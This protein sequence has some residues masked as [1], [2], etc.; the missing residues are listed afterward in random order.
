EA[1]RRR[2]PEALYRAAALALKALDEPELAALRALVGGL[3]A[4]GTI[5]TIASLCQ[6]AEEQLEVA[7]YNLAQLGLVYH[8]GERYTIATNSLRAALGRLVA[9]E[10]E[11][12][13]AVPAF[14][15]LA[16]ARF[17]DTAWLEHEW[18]NL[19]QAAR[20]AL[21]QGQ[22][23]EAASL[24]RAIQPHVTE[25]GLWQSWGRV[26]DMAGRAAQQ[27]GDPALRAWVLHEQGT[28]AGLLGDL[29]RAAESLARAHQLRVELGDHVGAELTQH[30]IEYFNLLVPPQSGEPEPADSPAPVGPATGPAWLMPLALA[31]V[32]L[33]AIGVGVIAMPRIN[34]LPTIRIASPQAGQRFRPGETIALRAS[35]ADAQ[36]QPLPAEA[37][38]WAVTLR[39]PSGDQDL[40][41]ST[42][43]GELSVTVPA[44]VDLATAS[45]GYLEIVVA[46]TDDRGRRGQ[47]T[48]RMD[49]V[50]APLALATEPPGFALAINGEQVATPYSAELWSGVSLELSAPDSITH[51]GQ[52]LR[53]EGW[54]D[55]TSTPRR[56]LRTGDDGQNLIAVFGMRIVNC[57][58]SEL[59]T[60]ENAGEVALAVSLDKPSSEPVVVDYRVEALGAAAGGDFRLNP[61]TLTFQPGQVTLPISVTIAED[62]VDEPAERLAVQLAP[63]AG[64]MPGSRGRCELTIVD[65]DDPPTVA[66]AGAAYGVKEG[67]GSLAFEIQLDTASAYTATARIQA[68]AETA[69]AGKDFAPLDVTLAF[70]PGEQRATATI[71]IIDDRSFEGAER[72]ALSVEPLE[73]L[74][75]GEP[76]R[77]YLT[78]EDDDAKPVL[79]LVGAS[80]TGEGA[81]RARLTI[82]SS[83]PLPAPLTLGLEIDAG[84]ATPGEDFVLPA[85]ITMPAGAVSAPVDVQIMQDDLYEG[86][87]DVALR[88]VLP[89]S[90]DVDLGT[91]SATLDIVEDEPRPVI[92]F[93]PRNSICDEPQAAGEGVR[94]LAMQQSY[95]SCENIVKLV[96]SVRAAQPISVE[97]KVEGD[98]V[99]GED[100]TLNPV[101]T[102]APRAQEAT[103]AWQV[104]ADGLY[105][106]PE[107]A[108]FRLVLPDNSV[109]QPSETIT[110]TVLIISWDPKP[111]LRLEY[112]DEVSEDAGE[113]VVSAVLDHPSGVDASLVLETISRPDPQ[114]YP[115][116]ARPG[117]DYEAKTAPL[118]IR[119]GATQ[120]Q[121]SVTIYRD[122]IAEGL[123][124]LVIQARDVEEANGPDPAIIE[125][126]IRDNPPQVGFAPTD[127]TANESSPSQAAFAFSA[128]AQIAAGPTVRLTVRLAQVSAEPVTVDYATVSG[129]AVAGQDFEAA[130]GSLTIAASQAEAQIEVTIL[131]DGLYEGDLPETFQ[132]VLSNA[133]GATLGAG[134]ATITIVD[135][136]SRPTISFANTTY[137]VGEGSIITDTRSVSI[138]LVLSRPSAVALT[139]DLVIGGDS[140]ATQGVD[141]SL[142]GTR[143]TFAPGVTVMT[144]TVTTAPDYAD[145]LN[146]T[147]NL[148]LADPGMAGDRPS[149]VVQINDDDNLLN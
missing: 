107:R 106:H 139:V 38:E 95:R 54:S 127:Y 126:G 71:A 86:D 65:N 122:E 145:E 51:Q 9:H 25:K 101:I 66:F 57:E 62:A 41:T 124:S 134:T 133:Q 125:I 87:E 77:A 50:K 108:I 135:S 141:Y 60:L 10:A 112:P 136:E 92:A 7:L 99:L 32:A 61:G 5:D 82:A 56:P 78:I 16:V 144:I 69:E 48:V 120:A 35:A 132:V 121:L 47:E 137:S 149:C 39:S 90:P 115:R 131:S 96:S 84:S 67:A 148:S 85:S 6:I 118:T 79:S 28:Q 44:Q 12:K 8:S 17:G 43:G 22:A 13:R 75:P 3:P 70:A 19:L 80:P 52:Q 83:Q 100:F 98:A 58:Q 114:T 147:V 116:P 81:G 64:A 40:A 130:S 27:S 72:L 15:A 46:A 113:V 110:A 129:S 89:A 94:S 88:L 29:D 30:N 76:S 18:V 103:L 73:Q 31:L 55:G 74:R 49:A 128:Q 45:G 59:E 21:S 2:R 63:R 138:D 140:T 102:F 14:A 34:P 37:L 104:S 97:V 119:K 143:V 109:A 1:L 23:N 68:R 123:E 111:S 146:E 93:S 4:G 42:A 142:S 33:V 117:S 36:E 11:R 26:I 20:T 91:A 105:E 53:F 24:L